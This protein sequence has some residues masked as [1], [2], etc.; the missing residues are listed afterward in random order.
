MKATRSNSNAAALKTKRSS[1]PLA[2]TTP[3]TSRL[4]LG[5]LPIPL[6]V[7]R[8]SNGRVSETVLLSADRGSGRISMWLRYGEVEKTISLAASVHWLRK[9]FT[10]YETAWPIA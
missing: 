1:A 7:L 4:H 5:E 3:L 10:Y 8:D 6:F 9:R 2:P